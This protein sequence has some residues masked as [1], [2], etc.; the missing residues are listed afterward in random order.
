MILCYHVV[1]GSVSSETALGKRLPA[2]AR[3][4]GDFSGAALT[5]SMRMM[6]AVKTSL[7]ENVQ[8]LSETWKVHSAPFKAGVYCD[9]RR[10]LP[11]NRGPIG[12]NVV[13]CELV[14]FIFFSAARARVSPLQAS[15]RVQRERQLALS[16]GCVPLF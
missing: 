9:G 7:S 10:M 11:V 5:I 15:T 2:F 14:V 12:F 3:E 8:A 13:L 1:G 16:G 4:R 6:S